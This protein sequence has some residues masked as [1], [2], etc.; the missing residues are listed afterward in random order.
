MSTVFRR[1]VVGFIAILVTPLMAPLQAQFSVD[2]GGNVSAT[3]F[4]G[5]GSGL[6]GIATAA[7]VLD[8]SSTVVG[9]FLPTNQVTRTGPG[10]IHYYLGVSVTTLSSGFG[11]DV[12]F[13]GED[14]LG[15]AF[16]INTTSVTPNSLIR[17][18][19]L[20]GGGGDHAGEVYTMEHGTGIT[21]LTNSSFID[22]STG[23]CEDVGGNPTTD[24]RALS[25]LE[26][27]SGLSAP[28]SLDS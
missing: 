20:M 6:T 21:S 13:T 18:G 23:D 11:V 19:I 4:A 25:L 2:N 28:F 22:V 16:T 12:H 27:L 3:S 1:L 14:C 9:T 15:T 7:T 24:G 26:D 8:A 17:P 5:D 10:G